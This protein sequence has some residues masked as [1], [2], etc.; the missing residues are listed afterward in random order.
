MHLLREADVEVFADY[1]QF[2][3]WDAGMG[4]VAPEDWSEQDVTNRAKMAEH[5]L[6]VCP[7]RN[8][9]VPVRITLHAGEPAF[10][11]SNYDHAV[12]ASVTLPTGQLQVHECTGGE[13]L[14]W[15]V[16]P[17][18]YCALVLFTGLGTLSSDGLEGQ[19]AYQV[20]LWPGDPMSLQ[21]VRQWLAA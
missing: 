18:T 6:V 11:L 12:R 21:V 7:V 3:V 15:K 10:D 14:T 13:V 8:M 17:G 5:V 2:Y 19:D 4:L 1:H 9:T 20:A 16:E